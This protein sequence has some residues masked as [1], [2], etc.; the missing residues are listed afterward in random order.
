MGVQL[1][2]QQAERWR[3]ELGRVEEGD[4][5]RTGQVRIPRS[6]LLVVV[7]SLAWWKGVAHHGWFDNKVSSSSD[8][9]Y[10]NAPAAGHSNVSGMLMSLRLD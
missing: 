5:Q 3:G 10:P 2:G 4:G 8:C 9:C 6:F 7:H 1:R